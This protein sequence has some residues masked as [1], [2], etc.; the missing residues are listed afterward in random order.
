MTKIELHPSLGEESCVLLHIP[1]RHIDDVKYQQQSRS[2]PGLEIGIKSEG[3]DE[4]SS[5]QRGRGF[6][7]IRH[8]RRPA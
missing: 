7:A 4:C 2:G 1:H 3:V 6:R 5:K 8:R